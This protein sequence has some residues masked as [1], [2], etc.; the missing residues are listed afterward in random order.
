MPLGE[1]VT[2]RHWLGLGVAA[3]GW[4]ADHH[5]LPTALLITALLPLDQPQRVLRVPRR[6][7]HDRNA[8]CA[9]R[10]ANK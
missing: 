5:G 2:R 1:R 10:S 3:L 8:A 6:H 7:H 4:V 9:R